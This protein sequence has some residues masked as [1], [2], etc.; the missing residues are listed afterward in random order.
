MDVFYYHFEYR[1]LCSFLA[2]ILHYIVLY[3]NI[4]CFKLQKYF[5]QDSVVVNRFI[6]IYIR[7]K[8]K[9]LCKLKIEAAFIRMAKLLFYFYI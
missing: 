8:T 2:Y 1:D 7:L 6:R 4:L 5:C 9:N 3:V